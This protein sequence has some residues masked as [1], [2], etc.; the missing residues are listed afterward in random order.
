MSQ[1]TD[2]TEVSGIPPALFRRPKELKH[3][4][5]EKGVKAYVSE[6][7]LFLLFSI[8]GFWGYKKAPATS[9]ILI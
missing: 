5:S 3:H 8:S 9:G 7:Y 6:G 2:P 1:A 4:S